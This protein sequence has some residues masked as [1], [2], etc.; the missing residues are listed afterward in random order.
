[1]KMEIPLK[2]KKMRRRKT[3]VLKS[4]PLL[5]LLPREVRNLIM[6]ISGILTP[7]PLSTQSSVK[8]WV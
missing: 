5:T 8:K 2:S 4:R 3:L 6:I 7:V 1:M